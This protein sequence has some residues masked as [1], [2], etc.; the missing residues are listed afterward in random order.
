MIDVQAPQQQ[1]LLEI[2]AEYLVVSSVVRMRMRDGYV[3]SR[4]WNASR[5][6]VKSIQQQQPCGR[7]N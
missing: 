2:P 1:L 3:S 7:E 5:Q 4:M 6:L